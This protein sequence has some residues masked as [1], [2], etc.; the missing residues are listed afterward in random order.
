[1]MTTEALE[2]KLARL[3]GYASSSIRFI[4]GSEAIELRSLETDLVGAAG[5]LALRIKHDR[6]ALDPSDPARPWV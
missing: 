5:A 2:R 3:V 4:G 1:M 6:L